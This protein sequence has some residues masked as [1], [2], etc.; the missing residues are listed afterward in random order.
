[1]FDQQHKDSFLCWINVSR[2]LMKTSFSSTSPWSAAAY[3]CGRS[4]LEMFS[5]L[6]FLTTWQPR[7]NLG[8]ISVTGSS[9][10]AS[11][12]HRN[13]PNT[14]PNV[15][16]RQRATILTWL[17]LNQFSPSPSTSCFHQIGRLFQHELVLALTKLDHLRFTQLIPSFTRRSLPE[18][19][20]VRHWAALF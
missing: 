12:S 15:S 14:V 4:L 11:H 20:P 5:H 13:D 9:V 6:F 16:V 18:W 17:R 19:Q 2:L 8:F 10:F 7:D 3:S 1:M